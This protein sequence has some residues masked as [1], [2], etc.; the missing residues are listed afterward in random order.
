VQ[1]TLDLSADI[2]ERASEVATAS[3]RTVEAVLEETLADALPAVPA[4]GNVRDVLSLMRQ[5]D[6]TVCAEDDLPDVEEFL[7]LVEGRA[8][9]L[10]ALETSESVLD[11]NPAS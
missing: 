6:V 2:L 11:E 10:P 7:A 3:G 8:V 5:L 1:T 4:N 9:G